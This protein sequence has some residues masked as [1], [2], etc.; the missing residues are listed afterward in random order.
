MVGMIW[1]VLVWGR[2]YVCLYV[3]NVCFLF[4]EVASKTRWSISTDFRW[5]WNLSTD[6]GTCFYWCIYRRFYMYDVSSDV[7]ICINRCRPKYMFLRK[8]LHASTD[9]DFYQLIYSHASVSTCIPWFIYVYTPT[10]FHMHLL[11]YLH[12]PHKDTQV[13]RRPTSA[14]V[15]MTTANGF[16]TWESGS[17]RRNPPA[18]KKNKKPVLSIP[19][20]GFLP[21]L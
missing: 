20:L 10:H 9:V 5:N 18:E 7:F 8:Y 6:V 19:S 15:T 17:A 13:R 4:C 1:V 12:S 16:R 11:M 21:G 14:T 3:C 2:A